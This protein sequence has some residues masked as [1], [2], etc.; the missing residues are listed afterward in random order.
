MPQGNSFRPLFGFASVRSVWLPIFC[1]LACLDVIYD[2]KSMVSYRFGFRFLWRGVDLVANVTVTTIFRRFPLESKNVKKGVGALRLALSAILV[3]ALCLTI[4]VSQPVSAQENQ[5]T[6][7]SGPDGTVWI[8]GCENRCPENLV[9]PESLYGN[10]VTAIADL[11]FVQQHIA[12]VTMPDSLLRIGDQ[13]FAYNNITSVTIGRFVEYIGQS[14][15]QANNLT[16][17]NIPSGVN[18]VGGA[19]FSLNPQLIDA[20]FYGDAPAVGKFYGEPNTMFYGDANMVKVFRPSN[21]L[22]WA[23]RFQGIRVGRS[24]IGLPVLPADI[25][26]SSTCYGQGGLA[27]IYLYADSTGVPNLVEKPQYSLD[28]GMT[29]RGASNMNAGVFDLP[30]YGYGIQLGLTCGQVYKVRVRLVGDFG[31]GRASKRIIIRPNTRADAPQ[32]SMTLS[33][34]RANNALLIVKLGYNGGSPVK[35]IRFSV[36][37]GDT[38]RTYSN[39]AISDVASFRLSGINQLAYSDPLIASGYRQKIVVQVMNGSGYWSDSANLGDIN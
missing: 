10:P 27:A 7:M 20:T 6:S 2:T 29:W 22:G 15:F 36:N 14:A 35:A 26:S 38:W 16:H 31:P 39:G 23:N 25:S 9:I 21:A 4:G 34:S 19:A 33:G 28:D 32:V 24:D 8:T 18:Y 5:F 12:T 13:A 1:L 30:G 3:G 17:V 11:A 37:A